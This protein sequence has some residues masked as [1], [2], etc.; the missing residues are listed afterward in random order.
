MEAILT[1]KNEIDF[2]KKVEISS[3]E[4]DS[5]V[6]WAF[7]STSL[8]IFVESNNAN[9][10]IE[11]SFSGHVVHGE[12]NPAFF[13]GIFFDNRQRNV[14]FLRRKSPGQSVVVRVEAWNC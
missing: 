3:T 1:L 11:Y 10:I 2:F 8:S 14:I 5:S 9:D 6:K 4:F 13:K 12:I 7:N